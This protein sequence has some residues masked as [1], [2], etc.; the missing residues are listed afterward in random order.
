MYFQ[1]YFS[2]FLLIVNVEMMRESIVDVERR[3]FFIFYYEYIIMN[4]RTMREEDKIKKIDFGEHIIG[5]RFGP[6]P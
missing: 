5:Y 4:V 3:Y 2:L 6:Y 1:L